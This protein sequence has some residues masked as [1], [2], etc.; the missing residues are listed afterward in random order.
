MT[1]NEFNEFLD[2]MFDSDCQLYSAQHN[3]PKRAELDQVA[4][5][6]GVTFPEDYVAFQLQYGGAYFQ[7]KEEVWPRAGANAGG[8]YWAFL[9][10]IR[11][12]GVGPEVPELLDIRVRTSQFL[13]NLGRDVPPALGPLVPVLCWESAADPVCVDKQGV[14]C[15]VS[16]E[17]PDRPTRIEKRFLDYLADQIRTLVENKAKVR[18]EAAFLFETEADRLAKRKAEAEKDATLTDRRCPSC[19]SPCPS[20]RKTCKVC[21]Y[22][23]GKGA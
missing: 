22:A 2:R 14:L 4:A 8:P 15:E 16:H 23:I 18:T 12:Y 17:A 11:V 6:L 20:Y 19:G 5:S 9:R 1:I 3:P 13:S 21:G 7:V 10:A